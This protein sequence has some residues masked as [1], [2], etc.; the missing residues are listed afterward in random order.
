[1]SSIWYHGTPD[2]RDL[3]KE[4]GFI[5]KTISTRYIK[6]LDTYYQLQS[7]MKEAREEGNEDAYHNYLDLVG[8]TYG[9]F[10]MRKPIFLSND[11]SVARTYTDPQ[12]AFDY[13][14]SKEKLLKVNVVD[15]SVVTI[16]A[17][18]DRF[19]F[20]D[21]NKVKRGFLN[22]GISE[23]D[24]DK[25]IKMFVYYQNTTK[26]I[27]TDV[28]AVI[29]EWFNFDYI[30]VLGVLDSYQGGSIKSTVRM[31]FEP[32]NI[33]I[34]N[35]N[36]S[37]KIKG[38]LAD[39]K[40]VEDIAKKHEVSVDVINKAIAK[41]VKVELEHTSDEDV[42]HEIAK[43]HVFENPK[44]YE[45]LAKMEKNLDETKSIIKKLIKEKVDLIV[46][47]ETPETISILV[48]YND[49][50]AGIII[51]TTS[52]EDDKVLELVDMKFKEG[53]EELHIMK[54]ALNGLWQLFNEINSIIVAPK[55]E[56]IAF[57]NK[58][59]FQRISPNYLISNR[60]H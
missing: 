41:G 26:G 11:S 57:W 48:E 58:M 39:N 10:K 30:D 22:A 16:V 5:H 18:G 42:A 7:K 50:N 3:E 1:M 21:L 19:R 4:G 31:V 51:V 36:E 55:P 46:T 23:E 38:G 13:Q 60:G 24:F 53:Y 27:K 29:G 8:K 25:V 33:K 49:R 37:D 35:M 6:D 14:N 9:E 28:I 2:V 17:T 56:S 43:D 59:G 47:D 52:P 15:G 34:L 12:R 45:G 44:Y 40:S 32:K 20:I 54:E